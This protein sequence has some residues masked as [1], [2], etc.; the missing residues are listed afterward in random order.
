MSGELR[1]HQQQLMAYL[2]GQDSTIADHVVDQGGITTDVRLGIYRN[3]Y[4][5]RLRET[6]DVDHPVLGT[7]LGDELFDRMVDG[8]IDQHPSSFSSLRQF[9]DRLPKFLSTNTPFSEHPQIAELARFERL[10]LTA[11][12]AADASSVPPQHL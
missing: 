9:A 11:F 12:D 6:I 4:R 10:L 1:E 3:A 5:I 7:Y 8:Y 2:L